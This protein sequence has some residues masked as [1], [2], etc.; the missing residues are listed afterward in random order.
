MYKGILEECPRIFVDQSTLVTLR[1]IRGRNH[2]LYQVNLIDRPTTK[3]PMQRTDDMLRG[4]HELLFR[5]PLPSCNMPKLS[6][7]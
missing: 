3:K 4:S 2:I 7:S 6:R 1:R 5:R